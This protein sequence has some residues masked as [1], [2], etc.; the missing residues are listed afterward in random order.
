MDNIDFYINGMNAIDELKR[1]YGNGYSLDKAK[2]YKAIKANKIQQE[3]MSRDNTTYDQVSALMTIA[4]IAL[5]GVNK[6]DIESKYNL[7]DFE[8]YKY[9]DITGV[10]SIDIYKN[11]YS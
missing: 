6:E 8:E 4:T 2:R 5:L 1:I 10:L 9:D 3:I 7:K 11:S